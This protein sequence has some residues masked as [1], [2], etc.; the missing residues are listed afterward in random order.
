MSKAIG[1]NNKEQIIKKYRL[2]NEMFDL[3]LTKLNMI[4]V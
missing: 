4:L 2:D 3:A 1:E